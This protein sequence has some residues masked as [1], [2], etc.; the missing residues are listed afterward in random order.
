VSLPNYSILSAFAVKKYNQPVLA[1]RYSPNWFQFGH[2]P[3]IIGCFSLQS[4]RSAGAFSKSF[5]SLSRNHGFIYDFKKNTILSTCPCYWAAPH[6][7]L[8]HKS[9]NHFGEKFYPRNLLL[10][11]RQT[12][13]SQN[14]ESVGCFFFLWVFATMPP[15]L[16]SF[17]T[18]TE[19]GRP[20]TARQ[21][22]TSN[23]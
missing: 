1:N 11:L 17:F 4:K 12:G 7:G 2:N 6:L 8:D 19:A 14:P 22:K 5:F 16:F 9:I 20:T 15:A 23:Y 13:F 3:E 21:A 18:G 10:Y